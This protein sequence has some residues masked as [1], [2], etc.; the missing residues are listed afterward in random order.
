MPTEA[1]R[2]LIEEFDE[3]RLLTECLSELGR[4][5]VSVDELEAFAI[6]KVFAKAVALLDVCAFDED[7]R[8]RSKIPDLYL[9]GLSMI[10]KG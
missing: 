5:S 4:F 6:K 7:G 9:A 1:F 3:L 10:H 8:S 2:A